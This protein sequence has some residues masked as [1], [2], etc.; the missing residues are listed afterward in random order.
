MYVSRSY[1][2]R[3]SLEDMHGFCLIWSWNP[4]TRAGI[5]VMVSH[6]HHTVVRFFALF[7]ELPWDLIR[8]FSL[9]IWIW[10]R[11]RPLIKCSF[12][13]FLQKLM[14]GMFC[15]NIAGS[16]VQLVLW[17]LQEIWY[18]VHVSLLTIH[19]Q[20]STPYS[21][22]FLSREWPAW[23]YKLLA[24]PPLYSISSWLSDASGSRATGDFSSCQ[25][26]WKECEATEI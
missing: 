19:D 26:Q 14:L 2:W 21:F 10:I 3:A 13:D 22:S 5:K 15:S 20:S 1:L 25:Q 9:Y 16:V 23:I 17:F 18:G 8:R 24:Y 12:Y 7:K 4:K 6:Q 11:L